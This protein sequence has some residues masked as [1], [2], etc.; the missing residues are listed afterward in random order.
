MQQNASVAYRVL[1]F[2]RSQFSTALIDG[3]LR[4]SFSNC[5]GVKVRNEIV[6][7]LAHACDESEEQLQ[8][9]DD[10]QSSIAN[11]AL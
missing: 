7:A 2:I 6:P 10:F 8:N 5:D 1:Q 11:R 3:L 9:S 4:K